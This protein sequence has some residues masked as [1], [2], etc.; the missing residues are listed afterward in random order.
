LFSLLTHSSPEQEA[1]RQRAAE[2]KEKKRL[3]RA[4]R[5]YME[6]KARMACEGGGMNGTNANKTMDL[7]GCIV[8]MALLTFSTLQ[9]RHW[10]STD[11]RPSKSPRTAQAAKR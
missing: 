9:I 6:H 1:E 2:T 8:P 3:L 4:E 10:N 11:R 7:Q 5:L